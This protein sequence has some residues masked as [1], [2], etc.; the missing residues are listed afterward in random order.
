M[1]ARPFALVGFSLALAL[2]ALNLV[3]GA[4]I[5]LAAFAFCSLII[6]VLLKS[7]ERR[8]MCAAVMLSVLLAC[9]VFSVHEAYAYAPSVSVAGDERNIS[10]KTV[11]LPSKN[12]SGWSY[13]LDVEKIDGIAAE[14]KLFL[15]V[16]QPLDADVFDTI[17]FT[18]DIISVESCAADILA[19]YKAKG[20]FWQCSG[21]TEYSV[22]PCAVK[23]LGYWLLSAKAYIIQRINSLMHGDSAAL[24]VGM[25]TG[26]TG[27]L[28]NGAY[29]AFRRTGLSHVLSVSGLHMSVIVLSLYSLLCGISKR[30]IKLWAVLCIA[31][32]VFY[33]GV[34]GFSQS[35]VRSAVMVCI[36]FFG[37]IIS[38]RAD[39]LNSLGLAAFAITFANPYAAVDWSF[40]LSFSA[41]LGI[42]LTAKSIDKFSASVCKK[43]RPSW[44]A[45]CFAKLINAA[46]ISLAAT[47]FCLPVTVFFIGFISLVFL[48]ANILTMYAVAA[49]LILSL[50]CVVPMGFVSNITA[51]LCTKLCDYL[52]A[53]TSW[54][55]DFRYAGISVDSGF[56]KLTVAAAVIIIAAA[57]LFVK[58]DK[59]FRRA[60]IA[61]VCGVVLLNTGYSLVMEA[62]RVDITYTDK[63]VVI[64]KAQDAVVIGSG[65][66]VLKSADEIL[67]DSSEN[68][69]VLL[70]CAVSGKAPNKAE[71]FFSK[72]NV[73]NV[74][75]SQQ[76]D[77]INYARRYEITSSTSF[78]FYNTKITYS[79]DYCTV[80]AESGTTAIVFGECADIKGNV[81]YIIRLNELSNGEEMQ[82][83]YNKFGI[84]EGGEASWQP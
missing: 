61:A 57:V 79:P 30:Y 81:D 82:L 64:L 40:M 4:A 9:A 27:F 16:E 22:I 14:G 78:D 49:G 39:T 75:A 33:A 3:E 20:I 53:V 10:A 73:K 13:I 36:V 70:P 59:I 34:S 42:V 55:S 6:C 11:S 46:G 15:T 43:I 56:A 37:R 67:Y 77:V 80:E 19:Y 8:G 76:N 60:C 48:P 26:D 69:T 72:Y 31:V 51:F 38:K 63:C 32:A 18:G 54:L 68:V 29:V 2:I 44:L 5:V 1:I 7:F 50:I 58:G 71:K 12:Q 62:D 52:L 28:S 65:S 45:V 47:V 21:V 25:L 41:T 23:P 74:V 17:A 83:S 84:I 24:A 66:N 35:V